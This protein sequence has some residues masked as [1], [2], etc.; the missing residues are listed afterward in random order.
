MV[1]L[2]A[3]VAVVA[4]AAF[5]PIFKLVTGVVEVTTRGAV[6]VATVEVN[7]PVSLRLVPVA[8][9]M[10]GVTNVGEVDRTVFPVPVD[11]VTPVPPFATASVALRP[12]AFPPIFKLATGVVEETMRG[13]VPVGT[14]E[15]NDPVSLRVV[16]VAPRING[17]TRVGELDKTVF[18]VPVEV[19]TPVPPLTTGNTPVITPEITTS[20]SIELE[21]G[22]KTSP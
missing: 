9:P 5:P 4:V 11:V 22:G 14:L 7:D 8:A 21:A 19:V 13:A 1:A 20:L 10:T 6:P 2:V 16:P 15:V 18:P 3:V 12:A 17:V